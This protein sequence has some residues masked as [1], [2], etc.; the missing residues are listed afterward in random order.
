[1]PRRIPP[2]LFILMAGF[3]SLPSFAAASRVTLD[4]V[5]ALLKAHVA[6]SLILRE[7]GSDGPAFELGVPA[8]LKL[9]EAG[10]SDALLDRLT[11]DRAPAAPAPVP[12]PAASPDADRAA[13]Y[14]IFREKGADGNEVLHVTNIDPQGHRMGGESTE[15]PETPNRY[16]APAP[17]PPRSDQEYVVIG[18]T[19]P[20][21][22]VVVNVYPQDAY[23]EG[24]YPAGYGSPYMYRD[25]YAYAYPRGIL[26]GY[27]PYFGGYRPPGT[28]APPG[29]VTH[30]QRYHADGFA[31][32]CNRPGV[33]FPQIGPAIGYDMYYRNTQAAFR[34]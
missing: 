2:A 11:A 18:E 20:A 29:S 1:M 16:E 22:P 27:R 23:G 15:S 3:V 31:A 12:A 30:F 5:V 21:Q 4:D 9:K 19:Q 33:T 17:Q 14:R 24:P 10:A 34:R 25:P 32:P 13:G 7:I 28:F 26:P 8:I 6:D